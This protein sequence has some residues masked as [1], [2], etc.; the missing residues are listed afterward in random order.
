MS[1][2]PIT[3][4]DIN[5]RDV[6]MFTRI[7]RAF[8]VAIRPAKMLLAL[9]ALVLMYG[10][11][12]VLDQAWMHWAP[13][14]VSAGFERRTGLDPVYVSVEAPF[15][16]F[17]KQQVGSFNKMTADVVDMNL[18]YPSGVPG[19]I[20]DFVIRNPVS[21]WRA[22][23]FYFTLLFVWFLLVWAVF[24]GAI[25]RIAAI[26][27]A[28]DEV[29]SPFRAMRFSL[30]A[31]PSFVAAPLIPVILIGVLGLLASVVGL[32]MYIPVVGP[33]LTGLLLILAIVLGILMTVLAV[34][35]VAG[36][37]LMYPTIAVE[38]SD[39]FDAVSRGLSHV[40]AAP[41]RMLFY[42][43]VAVVH[44]ALTYFFVRLCAFVLLALVHYFVGCFV[45]GDAGRMWNQ[46]WPGPKEY[47]RLAYQPAWHTMGTSGDVAAGVVSLWVYLVIALVGAYVVSYYFSASTIIYLLMRRKVDATDMDA[48][49]LEPA[50]EK[51]PEAPILMATP[52]A[53]GKSAKAE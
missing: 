17:L 43:G 10:G 38:G 52:E 35:A 23:S 44:G 31:M 24:G 45:F 25:C 46:I 15:A 48:V 27:V 9:V 53:E 11:G 51:V 42:S 6:F 13:N 33:I 26:H 1:E 47:A 7:F 4:Q 30:R 20:A 40:F 41:W 22:N 28:R 2:R 36:S 14:A 49:Y 37:G 50:D 8:R 12:R 29:I 5:W 32:P 16:A 3:I 39:A 21:F 18:G 19:A 34:G